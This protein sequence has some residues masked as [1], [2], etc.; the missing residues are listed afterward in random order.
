MRKVRFVS[1]CRNHEFAR[2]NA[3]ALMDQLVKCMLAICARRTPDD[4]S[5]GDGQIRSIHG[6]AFA[7]TLH[8]ELLQIGGKLTKTLI[9][10]STL[11]EFDIA[12]CSDVYTERLTQLIQSKVDGQELVAVPDTEEPKILNLMEAL[13]KGVAQGQLDAVAEV[14]AEPVVKSATRK[15]AAS[16]KKAA[17]KTTK[18]VAP[19]A[20]SRKSAARKKKSG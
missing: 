2:D 14:G 10:A 12:E 15:K 18:R 20:T 5:G 11:E 6:D 3:G 1:L 19:S 4:R 13:K 9:D 17:T 7:I 8:F 16:K